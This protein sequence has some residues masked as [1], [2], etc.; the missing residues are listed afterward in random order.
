MSVNADAAPILEP[1]AYKLDP[2]RWAEYRQGLLIRL[3]VVIPIVSAGSFYLMRYFE[4]KRDAFQFF[5]I[6]GVVMAWFVYRQVN[7]QRRNW[8]SLAFEFH[9][10]K[11]IRR[12]DEYPTVELV[13]SDVSAI[14]ESPR[15]IIV[16]TN[17]R[18]KKVFLSNKLTDYDGLR[19][20]LL[21]W[22]PT[23]KIIGWRRSSWGSI[24]DFSEVL[25]SLF[26]FLGPLYLMHTSHRSVILPLGLIL[27]FAA[28]G[29]ILYVRNSPAIPTRSKKSLWLLLLLPI[30]PMLSRLL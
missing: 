21:S 22:A 8:R 23:V 3:G 28:L 17:D 20:R 27:S 18:L 12:L 7:R 26:V 15:G 10:G 1:R 4:G 11:L 13:P 2:S 29:M 14:L 19:S 5:F 6:L 9:D 30:L 16:E 25:A 24:R